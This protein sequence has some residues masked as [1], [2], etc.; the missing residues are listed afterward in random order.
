[1][2]LPCL[3]AGLERYPEK[4]CW[5]AYLVGQ[6]ML[7]ALAVVELAG[8]AGSVAVELAAAAPVLVVADA[9]EGS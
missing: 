7:R 2:E 8:A 1:M 5:F 4:T 3:A 9:D 6:D